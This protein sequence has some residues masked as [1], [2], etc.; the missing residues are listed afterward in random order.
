MG[1]DWTDKWPL[2]SQVNLFD[3]WRQLPADGVA[4]VERPIYIGP[5]HSGLHKQPFIR[6]CNPNPKPNPNLYRV[7]RRPTHGS[8]TQ[9]LENS[10]STVNADFQEGPL[11]TRTHLQE[12]H[13]IQ[14]ILKGTTF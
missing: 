6:F 12:L 3:I 8:F 7:D 1:K 14:A 13:S 11:Q 5:S 9:C 4:E 2:W 10:K